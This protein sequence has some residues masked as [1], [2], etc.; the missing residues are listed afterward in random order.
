MSKTNTLK[1]RYM[2]IKA[3]KKYLSGLPPRQTKANAS[4]YS[5]RGLNDLV[6]L[7]NSETFKRHKENA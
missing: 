5:I 2:V 4:R 6:H 7:S 3:C 1:N